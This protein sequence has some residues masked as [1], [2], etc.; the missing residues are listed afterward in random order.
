MLGADDIRGALAALGAELASS[1]RRHELALVGGAAVVLLYGERQA[2]K[3][4]DAVVRDAAGADDVRSAAARVAAARGLPADWLNDRARGFLT[5]FD[6]GETLFDD[7]TLLVRAASAVQ[8]LAM[9]LSALRDEVDF[10]DARTLLRHIAGP[11]EHVWARLEPFLVPG[12]P[13][14]RRQNFDA[15]WEEIHG[16][17]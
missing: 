15:L 9:K 14:W 6:A 8:L 12:A 17:G 10:D 7:G 1:G 3:D 13:S 16:P 11:K 5:G 4:V 2:T